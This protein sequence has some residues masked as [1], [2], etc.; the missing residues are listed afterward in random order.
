M[1]LSLRGRELLL[2]SSL[3]VVALACGSSRKP[4]DTSGVSIVPRPTG[5]VD[6]G[7]TPRP[8]SCFEGDDCKAAES[9]VATCG[10]HQL[11]DSNCTCMQGSRVCTSCVLDPAFGG[12]LQDA[13][14]LCAPEVESELSC[15]TKGATCIQIVDQK[16]TPCLCWKGKTGLEWDCDLGDPPVSTPALFKDLA[17]PTPPGSAQDGPSRSRDVDAAAGTVVPPAVDAGNPS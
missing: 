10:V 5:G 15:P 8:N 12:M 2:A 4:D 7:T 3:A 9:C 14:E 16:R 17:P 11:G 6:A 13:N 1:N